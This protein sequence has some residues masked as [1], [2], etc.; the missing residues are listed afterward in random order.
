MS[1]E[2]CFA[3]VPGVT[4]EWFEYFGSCQGR[5]ACKFK[6]DG[7]EKP[8]YIIDWYGSCSGCDSFEAE[9]SFGSEPTQKQLA[10]F[11]QSYVDASVSLEQAIEMLIQ[12]PG[13]WQDEDDTEIVKRILKDYP[14]LGV[15]TG[16]FSKIS[17]HEDDK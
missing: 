12:P 17:G 7:E 15:K 3:A 13:E 9:F 5:M 6:K 16:L 1:Y 11:G 10:D 2:E 4:I 8:Q 14:D